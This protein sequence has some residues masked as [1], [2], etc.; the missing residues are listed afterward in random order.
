VTLISL[1]FFFNFLSSVSLFYTPNA[2]FF[3]PT[4]SEALLFSNGKSRCGFIFQIFPLCPPFR[5]P[6]IVPRESSPPSPRE[7]CTFDALPFTRATPIFG[8]CLSFPVTP[9][10]PGLLFTDH[11]QG[12]CFGPITTPF[13]ANGLLVLLVPCRGP[14][15]QSFLPSLTPFAIAKRA[16]PRRHCFFLTSKALL[17]VSF[18]PL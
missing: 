12:R 9:P 13:D 5:F 8:W 17:Y 10:P 3:C 15:F 6:R 16:T 18:L 2:M 7:E 11:I 14:L 4:A 1:F